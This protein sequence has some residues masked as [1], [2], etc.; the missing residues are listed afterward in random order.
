MKNILLIIFVCMS[1]GICV[2]QNNIGKINEIKLTGLYFTA[3]KTDADQSKAYEAAQND[4]LTKVNNERMNSGLPNIDMKVLVPNIQRLDHMRGD[5]YMV[6][7]YVEKIIMR[8]Q[9]L[10][11]ASVNTNTEAA[12][13]QVTSATIENTV[14]QTTSASSSHSSAMVYTPMPASSSLP[15]VI[16]QLLKAKTYMSARQ[17]LVNAEVLGEISKFGR[18]KIMGNTSDC[19]LVMINRN[20]EVAAVITPRDKDQKR[21]NLL[22]GAQIKQGDHSDCVPVCIRIK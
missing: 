1:W 4:L 15:P 18:A 11:T 9:S 2:A 3:E 5:S 16:T 13:Q 6:F 22:T 21:I 12:N 8:S 20:R 17:I 10:Q 7:L 19:Y 14:S